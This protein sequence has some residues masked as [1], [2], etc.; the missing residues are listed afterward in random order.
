MDSATSHR[1]PSNYFCLTVVFIHRPA[2]LC[3]KSEPDRLFSLDFLD[4]RTSLVNW[5]SHRRLITEDSRRN[6]SKC[7]LQRRSMTPICAP[8]ARAYSY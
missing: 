8:P 7:K 3:S 4:V 1:L 6:V 2:L 5:K